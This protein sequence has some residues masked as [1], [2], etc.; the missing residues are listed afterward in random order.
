MLSS[1]TPGTVSTVFAR[2]T[3]IPNLTPYVQ[4]WSLGVQREIGSRWLAEVDYVGTKS[5]HLDV[6]LNYNQPIISGGVVTPNVPYPNFGQVEYTS[7]VAYGNYNGLQMGLS[8][9]MSKGFSLHVAY[10]YSRSLDNAP[11][12]LEK[13]K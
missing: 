11:E 4:Q 10:T 5:T 6:L 3:Q 13:H 9:S 7:P 12:E 2:G 1:N 8:H